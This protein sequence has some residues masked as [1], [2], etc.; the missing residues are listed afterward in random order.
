M[1]E[2]EN[3]PPTLQPRFFRECMDM[4]WTLEESQQTTEVIQKYTL[5]FVQQNPTLSI[6]HQWICKIQKERPHIMTEQLSENYDCSYL[7]K[8]EAG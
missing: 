8:K 1:Q 7:N 3:R 6:G 5:F 4:L 2:L